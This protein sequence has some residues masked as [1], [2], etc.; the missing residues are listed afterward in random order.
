MSKCASRE[1]HKASWYRHSLIRQILYCVISEADNLISI[2]INKL[3]AF[4]GVKLSMLEFKA[5]YLPFENLFKSIASDMTIYN[6]PSLPPAVSSHEILY[7]RWILGH[8]IA[9]FYASE[10]SRTNTNVKYIF[11]NFANWNQHFMQKNN[12]LLNSVF[13]QRAFYT[14]NY[15]CRNITEPVREYF[16][17]FRYQPSHFVRTFFINA[18]MMSATCPPRPWLA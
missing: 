8:K 15:W 7:P 16:V 9:C 5:L 13:Y 14:C 4:K 2:L 6:T 18:Y 11:G 10:G 1:E 3:L 12:A 17:H